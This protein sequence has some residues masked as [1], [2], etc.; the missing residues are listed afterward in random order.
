M[1]YGNVLI[2]IS[3]AFIFRIDTMRLETAFYMQLVTKRIVTTLLN[4]DD[5]L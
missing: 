3:T 5:I 2:D 1:Y 4:V